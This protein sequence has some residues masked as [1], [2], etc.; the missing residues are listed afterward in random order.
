M[1]ETSM[2]FPP[3]V[4]LLCPISQNSWRNPISVSFRPN[5]CGKFFL[6]NHRA[7]APTVISSGKKRYNRDFARPF[8]FL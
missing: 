5:I 2:L 7:K 6:T 8:A 1:A 3:S 4:K